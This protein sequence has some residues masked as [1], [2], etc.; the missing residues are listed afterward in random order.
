LDG[1]P[2]I[3]GP[4][5]HPIRKEQIDP[6][7]L[8]VVNRLRGS[9]F[10]T[11]IVGGAVRD[12]LLGRRPKDF[13][14]VTSAR[15]EQI[16]PLFPKARI[17][18]RRFRLV[19]LRLSNREVEVSTFRAQS[20]KRAGALIQRDNVYGTPSADAARRDFSVNALALDPHNLTVIDYVG[21]LE[22]LERRVIRTIGTP[23]DSF[24]E[25]PV[26]ML[27]AVRF[28]V[29]LGF[30]LH[31]GVEAAIRRMA[32]GL[33][34]AT[35][36]R[37][38]EET[39]RFLTGGHAEATF[40]AF[41]RYGLLEPLLA[42]DAH[43]RYFDRRALEDPLLLLRPY[44]R[45]LDAWSAGGGEPV[46]PT[47]AL[48]GLLVTLARQ[49]LLGHFS[50]SRAA[51][52]LQRSVAREL[53]RHGAFMLGDWGLLKGQIVPALHILAS[54]R[55]L[56]RRQGQPAVKPRAPLGLR[57]AWML[58]I[59]TRGVLGLDESFVARGR[60]AIP[61]LPPMPILDH[62]QPWRQAKPAGKE[63][64]EPHSRPKR[65]RRRA[66]RRHKGPRERQDPAE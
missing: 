26:R 8:G 37:L 32:E 61:R 21:G 45:A 20:R 56:L 17:I 62:H 25:D 50:G 65:R 18:G 60:A 39:Q 9:G 13:D 23:E 28:Q 15:P 7:I 3:V 6:A 57:E 12:L 54:A 44:L 14:I 38:A 59:L 2:R 30:T 63:A 11:L 42:L 46:A 48:L 58:L 47:V 64:G 22:D 43:R 55:G 51:S 36:H 5:Q 41:R 33:R 29:R 66:G 4:D 1:S 10:L 34:E 16:K 24:G 31:P 19:L 35:R 49:E 52:P 40:E 53:T 27:R